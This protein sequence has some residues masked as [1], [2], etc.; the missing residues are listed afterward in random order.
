MGEINRKWSIGKSATLTD[1]GM[2]INKYRTLT[3]GLYACISVGVKIED[4]I[5]YPDMMVM[6]GSGRHKQ[7]NPNFDKD[8]F[9]GPPNF[10]LDIHKDFNSQYIIERKKLFLSSG[11]QEYLIVDENLTKFE[12][13]RLVKNKLTR[14]RDYQEIQ[15]DEKGIFKSECLPGLW[16]PLEALKQRN[17]FKIMAC[18][19][20]GVTRKP[21][22]ELMDTIWKKN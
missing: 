12:W 2:C 14:K 21:H 18:I 20:E 9:E 7:C 10:V 8:Y 4:T 3:V 11:V 15:P 22:H 13:N 6:I 1:L 17:T 19:E 5:I 16:I